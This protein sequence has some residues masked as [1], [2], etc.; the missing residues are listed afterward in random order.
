MTHINNINQ[1]IGEASVMRFELATGTKP[2]V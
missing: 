2:T 1:D